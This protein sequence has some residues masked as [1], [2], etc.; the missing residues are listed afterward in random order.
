MAATRIP[1]PVLLVVATFSRHASALEW[2]RRRL[3][4]EFGPVAL[5][6]PG[7][8]F[9]QTAYYESTMGPGLG[10]QFLAFCEFVAAGMLPASKLR[11][12]QFDDPL[13]GCGAYA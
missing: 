11:A 1:D 10:K 3:A 5:V 2:A 8:E 13:A 7:D 4:G 6:S 12:N 9:T